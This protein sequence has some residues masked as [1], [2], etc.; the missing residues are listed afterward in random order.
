MH[1]PLDYDSTMAELDRLTAVGGDRV[2]RQVI[3]SSVQGRHLIALDISNP[4]IEDDKKERAVLTAGHHG[5]E[6]PLPLKKGLK[7]PKRLDIFECL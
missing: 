2:H 7:K 5:M 3:G 1:T 4:R 6:I